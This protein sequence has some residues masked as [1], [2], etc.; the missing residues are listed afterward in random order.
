MESLEL[1]FNSEYTTYEKYESDIE[2]F[3]GLIIVS[4]SSTKATERYYIKFYDDDYEY[5][6]Y[7]IN[8]VNLDFSKESDKK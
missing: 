8:R 7:S 2:Y 1:T 5:D 4:N 6:D 3:D